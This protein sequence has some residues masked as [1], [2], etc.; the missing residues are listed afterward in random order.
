MVFDWSFTIEDDAPGQPLITKITAGN[1]LIDDKCYTRNS[2]P[3]IQV[4]Y[5]LGYGVDL[6]SAE[7][8]GD[9]T[10][11]VAGQ[12]DI[13]N[14]TLPGAN[15]SRYSVGMPDLTTGAYTLRLLAR[16]ANMMIHTSEKQP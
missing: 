14:L 9:P 1:C 10:G 2:T 15:F 5:N 13:E 7:I 4:F 11:Q 3:K 6:Q 16:K 8:I 12:V